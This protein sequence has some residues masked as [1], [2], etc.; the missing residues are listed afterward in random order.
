MVFLWN[1][2][3]P[4]ENVDFHTINKE[5]REIFEDAGVFEKN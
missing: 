3:E 1:K 2:K 5:M 4:A